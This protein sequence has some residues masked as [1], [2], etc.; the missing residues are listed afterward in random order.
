MTTRKIMLATVAAFVLMSYANAEDDV[1]LKDLTV[2][3]VAAYKVGSQKQSSLQVTASIDRADLT[4]ARG[5]IL[6]LRVKTNE[7]AYVTVFNVGPKGKV[8]QI[9]PN[10]FQKDNFVKANRE[11]EIPSADSK[12]EIKIAG[13]LGGEVVKV[14]ATNKQLKI[15]PEGVATPGQVFLSVKESV[16]EIV[17]N[18]EVTA[19]AAPAPEKVSIVSLAFKTV[20]SRK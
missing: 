17:R 13:D 3:Q 19:S 9:Y 2:E 6:K 10:N 20:A 14:F 18:L 16:P 7:D 11:V 8:T 12:A 5:D 15:V 1:I 4:Y